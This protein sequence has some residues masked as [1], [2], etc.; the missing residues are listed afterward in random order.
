[1]STPARDWWGGAAPVAGGPPA[2]PAVTSGLLPP[3]ARPAVPEPREPRAP[4]AVRAAGLLAAGS[5]LAGALAVVCAAAAGEP[6][7]RALAAQARALDPG[8][9][10]VV[11]D[12]GVGL[13]TVTAGVVTG[14]LL[15]VGAL[16]L[17][18][19][20]RRR[21][22]TRWLLL[23]SAALAVP[24][25]AVDQGLVAGVTSAGRA[26][27]LVQAALAVLAAGALLTAPV[28]RWSAAGS[29]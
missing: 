9:S 29:R 5:L 19:F 21:T 28:R 13:T 16:A 17:L 14:A 1:M 18:A 20:L 12:R 24:V 26:A 27:F 25:A 6:L 7:R 15:V 8:A 10:T 22:R 3:G 23:V 11:V 4:L 2:R